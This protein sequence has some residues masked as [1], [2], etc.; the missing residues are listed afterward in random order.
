MRFGIAKPWLIAAVCALG[1][2]GVASASPWQRSA[3]IGS[4]VGL[5]SVAR[6]FEGGAGRDLVIWDGRAVVEGRLDSG[7]AEAF[8]AEL[9]SRLRTA[10][11]GEGW[12]VPFRAE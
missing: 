3:F 10:F 1:A 5:P 7:D 12:S 8:A 9:D 11:D 4:P 2:A 6:R